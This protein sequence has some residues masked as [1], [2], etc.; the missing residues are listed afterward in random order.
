MA[1]HEAE[2]SMDSLANKIS[3]LKRFSEDKKSLI[4]SLE[5]Q[6]GGFAVYDKV[7]R[8]DV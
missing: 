2:N 8:A 4:L 3:D 1:Q 5:Q 6:N 7:T